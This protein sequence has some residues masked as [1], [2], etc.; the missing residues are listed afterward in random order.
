MYWFYITMNF[1]S[2]H[3]IY[4]SNLTTCVAGNIYSKCTNY[5]KPF[6]YDLNRGEVFSW[7]HYF[8]FCE[9]SINISFLPNLLL[10]NF[11][12]IRN[13]EDFLWN[14]MMWDG[15]KIICSANTYFNKVYFYM[16]LLLKFLVY[17][18]VLVK[19]TDQIRQ[20]H[21][22]WNGSKFGACLWVCAFV[23]ICMGRE[24]VVS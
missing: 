11:K 21:C 16:C 18:F 9:S 5:V 1:S 4:Y 13:E 14:I 6:H 8:S 10:S 24:S 17:S 23:C 20:N 2:F 19:F 12:I 22:H 3:I 15:K 7:S